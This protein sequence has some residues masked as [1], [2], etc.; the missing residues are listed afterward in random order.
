MSYINQRNPAEEDSLDGLLATCNL[1]EFQGLLKATK[2]N[3]DTL[4]PILR[5]DIVLEMLPFFEG[6]Q[7]D[8]NLDRGREKLEYA[9]SHIQQEVLTILHRKETTIDETIDRYRHG[10]LETWRSLENSR[11]YPLP[12]AQIFSSEILPPG[13]R[14][15][16]SGND[17][18]HE[19]YEAI[20][21]DWPR[22]VWALDI[23]RKL[24]K[25]FD[26]KEHFFVSNLQSR[27]ETQP[28][29]AVLFPSFGKCVFVCNSYSNA[30]YIVPLEGWQQQAT[31]HKI[32][33]LRAMAEQAKQN[34][35]N[36][37][38]P[39]IGWFPMTEDES[40][41]RAR[42]MYHLMN[43]PSQQQQ[44][45]KRNRR[46]FEEWLHTLIQ[47]KELHGRWPSSD[48]NKEE[49]YRLG[50]KINGW[51]EGY[52]NKQLIAQQKPIRRYAILS[53]EHEN[54]IL[55]IGI[56][57]DTKAEAEQR[58][59]QNL[60]ACLEFFRRKGHWPSGRSTEKE[61]MRLYIQISQWRA[62]WRNK[63]L[64]DRGEPMVGT[65]RLSEEHAKAILDIGIILD[66]KAEAEEKFQRDFNACLNF[67][68]ENGH[69]PSRYSPNQAEKRLG[70]SI[71]SW[72][73]GYR[74]EQ[75]VAQSKP[76]RGYARLSKEHEAALR[77]A[78]IPLD[79]KRENK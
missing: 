47:F 45:N 20:K 3:I 69:W 10:L 61:E 74:N 2:M 58:F 75:L 12:H 77:A 62:G 50:K 24:D 54:A 18:E 43:N 30:T 59:W 68:Q 71:E 19:T 15:V 78:G 34:P 17:T 7:R 22:L 76:M 72:G 42:L 37:G 55:A 57:L 70:R 32:E 38:I 65:K 26:P 36:L 28:Y 13:E 53:K 60:L 35:D 29:F 40:S 46:T 73:S 33:D 48:S 5:E 4:H 64:L 44:T 52:R 14:A 66:T 51:R 31:S 25:Q 27:S 63:Q 11:P 1:T 41:W 79:R 23:A 39:R 6:A 21:Q 67:F 16:T 56:I 49:E 9:C 8:E